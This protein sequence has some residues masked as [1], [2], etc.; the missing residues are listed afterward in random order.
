MATYISGMGR[1]N[2]IFEL[3]FDV[4]YNRIE[5]EKETEIDED[6]KVLYVNVYKD[7]P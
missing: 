6:G 1:R 3:L 4:A 7:L 2:F 5:Q